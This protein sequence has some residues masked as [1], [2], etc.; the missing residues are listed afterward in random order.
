M[1]QG[2]QGMGQGSQGMI[3]LS[4]FSDKNS[5]SVF[6]KK[7][8]PEQQDHGKVEER[9]VSVSETSRVAEWPTQTSGQWVQGSFPRLKRPNC[10]ANYS[11]P[12]SVKVMNE[13]SYI[14]NP[15]LRLYDANKEN[16]AFTSTKI[17]RN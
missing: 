1:N 13:G 14:S 15:P 2:S 8:Y 5:A 9:E 12:P 10:E 3:N 4:A 6:R 11:H 16:L 17:V 7:E